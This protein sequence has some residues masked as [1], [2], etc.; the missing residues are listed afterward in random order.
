M[1]GIHDLG[2][3]EGFGPVEHSEQ[4][5]ARG[6]FH[7]HWESRVFAMAQMGFA[8]GA[9]RNVDHFRH[10]IE[11]IN[12]VAYLEDGYYGRWLGGLE[13]ALVEAELLPADAVSARA[14]RPAPQSV[15]PEQEARTPTAGRAL[16]TEAVFAV[17]ARVRTASH[18]KPGHTRLPAYVRG[19][20]GTVVALHGGWVFPDTNA[21]GAGEQPQ[22]LYTVRFDGEELWGENGDSDLEVCIDLFE[23]YLSR[24]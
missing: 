11:R 5:S 14:A 15:L 4:K 24:V 13:T 17:G 2:G 18:G 3:R 9:F 21:H 20:V 12:P 23:S 19:R 10:A 16:S 22:H 8:I 1:D 7:A 6:P